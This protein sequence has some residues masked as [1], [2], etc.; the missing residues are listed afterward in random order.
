MPSVVML[1]YA[2]QGERP[3]LEACFADRFTCYYCNWSGLI[4]ASGGAV[5]AA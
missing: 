5:A 2:G 1:Q 4:P 3:T